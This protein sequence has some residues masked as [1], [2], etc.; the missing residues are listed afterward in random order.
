MFGSLGAPEIAIIGVVIILLFGVGK[1][2]GL[3]KDLGSSVKEFRR[4]IKDE[5]KEKDAPT[6]QQAQPQQQI[7]P[8]QPTY[9]AP[10][11]PPVQQYTPPPAPAQPPAKG[12][13]S[14]G[15]F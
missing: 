13:N 15:I 10:A 8:A 1:L 4:A 12:D 6:V 9:A 7:Q 5:D 3:G 14:P 2:A 11:Q